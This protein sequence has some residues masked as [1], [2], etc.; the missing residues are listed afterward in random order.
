MLLLG[1]EYKEAISTL[2]ETKI[3]R[4][5]DSQEGGE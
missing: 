4:L 1:E 2:M 3:S 5:F